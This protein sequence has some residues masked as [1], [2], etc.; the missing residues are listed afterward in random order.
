V[1]QQVTNLD[2]AGARFWQSAGGVWVGQVSFSDPAELLTRTLR[3]ASISTG[4]RYLVVDSESPDCPT[5]FEPALLEPFQRRLQLTPRATA[6]WATQTVASDAA[7]HSILD[8]LNKGDLCVFLSNNSVDEIAAR[9]LEPLT[10]CHLNL[11]LNSLEHNLNQFRSLIGPDCKITAMIKASA[12]G[13]SGVAFAKWLQTL[14]IDYLGVSQVN[15]GVI[16]RKDDIAMP[17]LTIA[18][19]PSELTKAFKYNLTPVIA[20]PSVL[21]ELLEVASRTDR[22]LSVHLDVDSGMHRAGFLPDEAIAAIERL[23]SVS[24]IKLEGLMSHFASADDPTK[25]EYNQFQKDN[26]EKVWSYS[27]S[28]GLKPIRHIC[29]TAGTLRFPESHFEMVRLGIGIH[30]LYPSPDTANLVNLNPVASLTTQVLQTINVPQSETVGY[31]GTYTAPDGGAVIA[32]V[33]TGY[34][35]GMPR[36][37]SNQGSVAIHGQVLPIVGNISMDSLT[38]DV[39]SLPDVKAGDE[40]LIF[41]FANSQELPIEHNAQAINTIN[42]EIQTRIGPR[43]L[44]IFHF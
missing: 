6:A 30:G 20:T 8:E 25:D 31:C 16:L 37:L 35:E 21:E 14:Q 24:N 1:G 18:P 5:S 33:P 29:N 23:A 22:D 40:V 4:C 19:T 32:T 2:L 42:Y 10:V 9:F 26:F 44:R 41:G 39:S 28:I 27:A 12:Y 38:V 7:V 11:D 34:F 17:I 13:T 15:E 43:I 36:L 3:L